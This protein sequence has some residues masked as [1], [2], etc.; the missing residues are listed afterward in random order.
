[1][2]G[3]LLPRRVERGHGRRRRRC[4]E[5]MGWPEPEGVI[6]ADGTAEHH[7]CRVW[8]AAE[9]AIASPDAL[10][11]PAEITIRGEYAPIANCEVCR[12]VRELDEL[13]RCAECRS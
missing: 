2:A 5:R 8:A 6:Y 9:R 12:K 10:A 4:G 11:D 13:G 1:M 7:R 3:H